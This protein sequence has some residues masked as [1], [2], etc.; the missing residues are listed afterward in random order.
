M[1]ALTAL[2]TRTAA[3]RLIEP[4]PNAVELEQILKAGLR[5]P[6]GAWEVGAYVKNVGNVTRLASGDGSPLD[7]STTLLR[8]APGN[9]LPFGSQTYS[10]Y[11]RG[12]S[13][14]PPREFGVSMRFALGAR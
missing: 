12:V 3:P 5:A 8:V 6:D 2:Q 14:T 9:P 7:S 13:V 10:S 4:A 11:Y 1:D